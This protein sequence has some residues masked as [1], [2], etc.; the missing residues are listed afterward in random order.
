MCS[1]SSGGESMKVM[2]TG[3]AGFIGGYLVEELLAHGHEVVGLDN[4]SK[5][6]EVGHASRRNPRYRFVRG[7]A[8]DAALLT[9]LLGDCDHLVAGAAMIGGIS[10]FHQF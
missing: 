7:D 2:V 4:F 9:D 6:G 10:Y 3:A 8:K 1:I 5:Y